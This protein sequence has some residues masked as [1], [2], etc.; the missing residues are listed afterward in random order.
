MCMYVYVNDHIANVA[1]FVVMYHNRTYSRLF[2]LSTFYSQLHQLHPTHLDKLYHLAK[3]NVP[4]YQT[5]L[6]S[7]LPS[8]LEDW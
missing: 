3:Q 8:L 7:P 6:L 5:F 4:K 2:T 1:T